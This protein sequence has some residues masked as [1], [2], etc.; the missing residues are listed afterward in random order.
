MNLHSEEEKCSRMREE[1]LTV[2]EDLSK[3]QL[4]RDML[5]QQKIETDGLLSQIEKSRGSLELDFERVILE[6]SDL[7]E[8]LAKV[9]TVCLTHEK[10]K[11]KLIEDLKKVSLNLLII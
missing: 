8:I 2:R 4:T 5:E 11:D 6:K 9:E 10:D 3:T 1:L 7:Q